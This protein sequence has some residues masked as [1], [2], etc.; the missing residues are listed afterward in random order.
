ARHAR[1]SRVPPEGAPRSPRRPQSA[2]RAAPQSAHVAPDP[3]GASVG[4]H[5]ALLES[6]GIGG[7]RPPSGKGGSCVLQEGA[8]AGGRFRLV[9]PIGQGGM[10][11]VWWAHD[12]HKGGEVAIKLS[13][14]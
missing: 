13:P 6:S 11:S 14:A 2:D 12:E 3:R 8:I 1:A 10:A 9:R 5:P 7:E 4:A